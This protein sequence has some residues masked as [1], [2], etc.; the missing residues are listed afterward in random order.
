MSETDTGTALRALPGGELTVEPPSGRSTKWTVR[1]GRQAERVNPDD[2]DSVRRA[3]RRLGVDPDVIRDAILAW[4]PP[5]PAATSPPTPLQREPVTVRVRRI[6]EPDSAAQV[7][8]D[9]RA[10]L[11]A[12]HALGDPDH[13]ILKWARTSA[14]RLVAIDVDAHEPFRLPDL[15]RLTN[16][17]APRPT[18]AWLTRSGGYRFVFENDLG[19]YGLSAKER[20]GLFALLV[21]EAV[22]GANIERVELKCDTRCPPTGSEVLCGVGGYGVADLRGALM[23]T[24][25]EDAVTPEAIDAWLASHGMVRGGRYEHDRCPINP[26]PISGSDPVQV[27]DDG[28]FCYRCAASGA[29]SAGWR[30][31]ARL[32]DRRSEDGAIGD[33]LVE[34]AVGWCHWTHA[35]VVVEALRPLVPA[36][37]RAAGYRALLRVVHDPRWADQETVERV[38]AVFNPN[39]T[40]VRGRG[41]WLHAGSLR[42]HEK[43]TAASARALPAVRGAFDAEVFL[44]SERL[45]GYVPVEPVRFLAD[46]PTWRESERSVWVPLPRSGADPIESYDYDRARAALAD[47]VPGVSDRWLD[48]VYLHVLAMVRAQLCLATPPIT[49]VHGPSGSGKGFSVH[50]ACALVGASPAMLRFD[51]PR[52]LGLSI[53]E[54]LSA[55]APVLFGDEVGKAEGFWRQSAPILEL[56][57]TFAWR[58]LHVGGTSLPMRAAVVLAGSTLP[59]GLTTMQELARRVAMFELPRVAIEV[60]TR[61]EGA[62]C[63][64]FGVPSLATLRSRPW[65]AAVGDAYVARA[66]AEVQA[67]TPPPWVEQAQRHGAEAISND[68][69]A[70]ELADLVRRLYA[71]WQGGEER[72]PTGQRFAGWLRCWH[73]GVSGPQRAA[74]AL[75]EYLDE[76]DSPAA[77]EAKLGRLETAD[78][79]RIVPDAPPLMR[80]VARAHGRR[81]AVRFYE[82]GR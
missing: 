1:F 81:V 58:A 14:H 72:V 57:P 43:F 36:D 13:V 50:V 35:S 75:A 67:E 68:D 21:P 20:A 59:R 82:P 7:F 28:V 40:V 47:A 78:V 61:W 62:I 24:G 79:P 52:E 25:G 32:V 69:E 46:R 48:L 51:G 9:F 17:A 38:E 12:A 10:A 74:E 19:D 56:G 70:R 11:D 8:E 64:Y 34:S 6:D 26:G 18:W 30:P 71:I 60:S 2:G 27:T 73:D 65:G 80:L 29:A 77:R 37:L 63:D 44:S 76:D 15:L 22:G 55:G 23:R 53:G 5:P 39:L 49:L 3:A 33:P 66:L 16:R 45:P 54:G 4:Q 31:W 41:A 42:R